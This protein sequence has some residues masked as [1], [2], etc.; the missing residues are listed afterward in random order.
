MRNKI[1]MLLISGFVVAALI[2]TACSSGGGSK[3]ITKN[4]CTITFSVTGAAA[5]Y[6]NPRPITV[7]RKGTMDNQ[8]P[9]DPVNEDSSIIFYGWYDSG[10][11]YTRDTVINADLD[12]VARW[13]RV[14]DTV[15]VTFVTD[16]TAVLPL[17]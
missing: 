13:V 1:F 12:L 16:G 14:V 7:L 17:V 10:I 11:H 2:L 15:T 9:S 6:E 5:S 3:L 8:Y 4:Q